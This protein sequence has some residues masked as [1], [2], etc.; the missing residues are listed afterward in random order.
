MVDVVDVVDIV[1]TVDT[2]EELRVEIHER[3]GTS[4][5]RMFYCFSCSSNLQSAIRKGVFC[6]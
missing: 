1:E 5:L 4:E 2:F 3:L 6:L